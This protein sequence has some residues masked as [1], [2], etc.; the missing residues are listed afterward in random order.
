MRLSV[1]T[2]FDPAL[3]DAL[4]GYPVV[5]LFGKLRE[6]AVGGGVRAYAARRYDGN[7]FDLVQPYA[8]QEMTGSG[9]GGS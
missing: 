8:L 4:R 1:A 7:L 9:R 3:V 5:E 2:N 6:D